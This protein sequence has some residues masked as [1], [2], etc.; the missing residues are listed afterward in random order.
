[1]KLSDSLVLDARLMAETAARSIAGQIEF[2]AALGRAIEPLLRMPEI[3]ALRKAGGDKPLSVCLEEV[4]SPA[5]QERVAKYL[6]TRPFPHY[7]HENGRLIRIDE[8]GARTAGRFVNRQFRPS[9]KR[10][11]K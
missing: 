8:N 6:R 5:G 2:W 3:L 7:E 11:R 1:M 10:A 4:D 9:R